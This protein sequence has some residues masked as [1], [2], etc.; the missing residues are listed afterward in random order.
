MKS[1]TG[2]GVGDQGVV[3]GGGWGRKRLQL[4]LGEMNLNKK[5]IYIVRFIGI[6]LY[7]K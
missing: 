4:F 5:Y 2:A 7:E 6:R 3:S 1:L